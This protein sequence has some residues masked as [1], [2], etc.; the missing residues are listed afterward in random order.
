MKSSLKLVTTPMC[1][2][3]VKL[4]GISDYIVSKNPDSVN[5]DIAVVLSETDLSTKSIKIKLN[6][7]SQI[8]ESI[9]ILST[10]FGTIPL[11]YKMK[12]TGNPKD[13]ENRKIKVR[14][15]SNFLKEIVED[16][17]FKIVNDDYN[18]VVYP[19]YMKDKIINEIEDNIKAV[20]IPSHKNAPLEAIKRA[21]MR[22][23][24]LEK[25]LCMKP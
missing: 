24:I 23:N 20:E 3:I 11:N 22:Y 15:Y 4:A 18:F 9:E 14:V 6:T 2:E 16:M 25:E 19:D 10:T 8:T 21:E 5:A 7:L 1:E 12:N 17:G 13:G